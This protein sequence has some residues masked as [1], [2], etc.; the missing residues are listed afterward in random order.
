MTA[1]QVDAR[2]PSR[3]VGMHLLA[4]VVF[5]LLVWSGATML[6]PYAYGMGVPSLIVGAAGS[7]GSLVIAASAWRARTAS[8]GG[9]SRMQTVAR[10]AMTVAA[11]AAMVAGVALAP[12]GMD[13]GFVIAVALFHAMLLVA[14]ALVCGYRPRTAT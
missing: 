8:H 9:R 13:R 5:A 11:V 10:L 12:G 2:G 6:H 4:A 14:Y 3:S 7:A 1:E